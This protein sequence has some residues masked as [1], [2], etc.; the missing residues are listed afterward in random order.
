[1]KKMFILAVCVAGFLCF[2]KYSYEKV[3]ASDSWKLREENAKL[4][5]KIKSLGELNESLVSQNRDLKDRILEAGLDLKND[6]KKEEKKEVN[7][8]EAK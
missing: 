2:A 6:D 7:K 5:D 4:E 1:M 8:E 3:D